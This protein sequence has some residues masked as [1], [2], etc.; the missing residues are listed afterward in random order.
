[1]PLRYLVFLLV[2]VAAILPTASA[3]AQ[4]I[5]DLRS[6]S[7]R[8]SRANATD[9]RNDGR[10]AQMPLVESARASRRVWGA[11]VGAVGGGGLAYWAGGS[12]CN[13]ISP[14]SC[15]GRLTVYGALFGGVLGYVAG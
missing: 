3:G 7:M 13:D 14:G 6:F 1:M 5:A 10:K 9:S 8:E 2:F 11:V 12:I 15:R 4:R